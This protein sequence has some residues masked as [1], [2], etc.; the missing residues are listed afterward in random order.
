[1]NRLA[2]VADL[3]IDGVAGAAVHAACRLL[4]KP[5]AAL[6]L[7]ADDG[8]ATVVGA[9][10]LLSPIDQGLAGALVRAACE[11]ADGLRI[12]DLLEV[13]TDQVGAARSLGIRSLLL[14]P[15]H[16]D[17]RIAGAL[18]VGGL[19]PHHFTDHEREIAIALAGQ[20][21]TLLTTLRLLEKEQAERRRTQVLLEVAQAVTRSPDLETALAGICRAA[22][23]FSVA[24]R[25]AIFL[26]DATGRP[27]PVIGW[28]VFDGTQ[29][30][31]VAQ[32][33]AFQRH[34]EA[35]GRMAPLDKLA[36]LLAGEPVI[37]QDAAAAP[38]T[39]RPWVDQFGIKSLAIYPLITRQGSTGLMNLTSHDRAV[40]FPSDEIEAMTAIALQAA[41][42]IEHLSLL[43]QVREQADRDGLTGL[44]NHRYLKQAL[45]DELSAAQRTG[46]SLAVALLDVDGMKLLNDSR[47]HSAGDAVL[48]KVAAALG[49]TFRESDTI[50]R[51]GGDEFLVVMPG[52]DLHTAIDQGERLLAA[53]AAQ[54]PSAG[55]SIGIAIAPDD[56]ATTSGLLEAADAAMYAAKRA[57]LGGI[58]LARDQSP[59]SR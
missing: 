18:L 36:P 27:R 28:D 1:M 24:H 20:A 38:H 54:E 8:N 47:G 5:V 4:D 7:V 57:G 48:R 26:A 41:A 14:A 44:Y 35:D 22:A 19:T 51:Y 34:L 31:R 58:A 29:A 42:V 2:E 13:H 52:T 40:H 11:R 59:T 3:N 33:H 9:A 21:A 32:L 6:L 43:Q 49:E 53:I 12:A 37:L 30:E 56:A 46:Q 16:P 23:S 10:G 17:S 39:I 25:C 55:A 45:H 50:A 15:L